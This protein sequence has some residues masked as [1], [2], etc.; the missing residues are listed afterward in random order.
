MKI[1]VK[2]ICFSYASHEVLDRVALEVSA[3]E[4]LSIV[5]PNGSGKSTLLKCMARILKPKSGAVFLDGKNAAGIGS[6]ELARLM[7]YV[8][9]SA[10]E[11]FPFTVLETVLMGRKPHLKWGVAK[12]DIEV[13]SEVIKFMGIEEMAERHLDQLSGGQKQKVFIARALAQEPRIFLFDEPTSSLDIRHQLEVLETVREL[14]RQKKCLVIM[15]IHDLNLASRFSDKM[16]MLKDGRVFVA[17][18]PETVITRENIS[19]VYGVEATVTESEFGPH[20]I[21]IRPVS[22]PDE[23]IKT[24]VAS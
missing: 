6:R 7:G 20:V 23:Y 21:P 4:I 22:D 17:G 19:V 14:A 12:R 13:V 18:E 24:A 9:Q 15:V 5:G 10:A 2:D 16:V 8:P 11:V 3:G 1:N